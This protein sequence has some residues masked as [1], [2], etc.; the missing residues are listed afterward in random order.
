M[1][2][3]RLRFRV[4]RAWFHEFIDLLNEFPV[5]GIYIIKPCENNNPPHYMIEY[6]FEGEL[7]KKEKQLLT[8]ILIKCFLQK[9]IIID[10]LSSHPDVII[11]G[12][13]TEPEIHL[14][15]EKIF[16]KYK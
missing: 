3:N 7:D 1:D 14:K 2:K 16:S 4:Q 8:D 10:D 5:F 13:T 12:M 11:H 9:D 6:R 15:K